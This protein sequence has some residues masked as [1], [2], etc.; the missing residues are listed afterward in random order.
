MTQR[1]DSRVLETVDPTAPSALVGPLRWSERQ[2]SPFPD[3]AGAAGAAVA[4]VLVGVLS[5]A[6]SF[7]TVA[8]SGSDVTAS[9]VAA[10]VA[11]ALGAA[12]AS[13][14]TVIVHHLVAAR[15]RATV[16]HVGRDGVERV[17]ENADGVT[18]E[19]VAFA[20]VAHALR[21]RTSRRALL[22][23]VERVTLDLVD[24]KGRVLFALAT[25]HPRG[26][27]TAAAALLAR[28]THEYLD[29]RITLAAE[30]NRS[31]RAASSARIA[32]ARISV[33]DE[34]ARPRLSA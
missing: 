29:R 27:P 24:A 34:L 3:V 11:G 30:R 13:A 14:L 4:A 9:P 16:I 15:P 7:A 25:D 2:T 28:V 12:L 19:G 6:F 8:K 33:S 31:R 1:G 20:D 22:G 10:L 21:E 26:R 32:V 5:G 18:R 23:D 17:I